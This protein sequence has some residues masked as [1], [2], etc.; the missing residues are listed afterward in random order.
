ML[1]LKP[2]PDSNEEG[3]GKSIKASE[4]FIESLTV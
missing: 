3:K 4:N 1:I 2:K